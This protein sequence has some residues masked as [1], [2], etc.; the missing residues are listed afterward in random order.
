MKYIKIF[1]LICLVIIILPLSA[2]SKDIVVTTTQ[3]LASIASVI[4][5]DLLDIQF[6]APGKANIHLIELKPSYAVKLTRAKAVI[7]MGMS[8]DKWIFRLIENSRNSKIKPGSKGYIDAS[9]GCNILGQGEH[10][11]RT[12]GDVHPEGNPHYLLDPENGLIIARNVAEKFSVLFPKHKTDF[13]ANLAK[14]ENEYNSFIERIQPQLELIKGQKVI[15]YHKM[16]EYFSRFT[17]IEL[18]AEI[19]PKPGIPPTARHTGDLIRLMKEQSIG[20]IIRSPFYEKRT[21]DKI[22]SGTGAVV[23]TL[24][25]QVGAVDDVKTY[26]DMFEFNIQKI[27]GAVNAKR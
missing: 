23:L 8:F 15:T 9:H 17:G 25:P 21:A 5:G 2:A 16:W 3:D 18:T 26:F 1:F 4:A 27:A 19:E 22:A 24:A 6:L 7:I 20:I 13:E 12:M 14:F 10:T 11:D